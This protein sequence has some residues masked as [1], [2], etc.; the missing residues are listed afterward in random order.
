M[1][2]ESHERTEFEGTRWNGVR[3]GLRL[4]N[5]HLGG[6]A[7]GCFY[8][9]WGLIGLLLCLVL[10]PVALLGKM[11]AFRKTANVAALYG[12]VWPMALMAAATWTLKLVSRVLWCAVPRPAT[13][14][15]LALV[16]VAGRLCILLALGSVWLSGGPF[17]KGLVRPEILACSGIAC[18]GLVAE[19]GFV[20]TLRRQYV[21]APSPTPDFVEPDDAV[22]DESQ[23]EPGTGRKTKTAFTRDLG[24]WFKES[25]PRASKVVVW[26]LLPLAYVIVASLAADGNPQAVP[27]AILRSAVIAPA[28]LQIFWVPSSAI[29]ELIVALSPRTMPQSLHA[30]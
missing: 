26:A 30:T 17:I 22:D 2:T 19:W 27:E 10:I 8:G 14:R 24:H 25:F 1:T 16:S 21:P 15:A 28:F 11:D 12:L 3:L 23:A 4:A 5:N 6:I 20:R 29:D 13:A 7:M 9:L 18:L